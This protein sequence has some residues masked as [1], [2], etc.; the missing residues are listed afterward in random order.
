MKKVDEL[1]LEQLGE[2]EG[3]EDEECVKSAQVDCFSKDQEPKK[4]KRNISLRLDKETASDQELLKK[5]EVCG[6]IS[7]SSSEN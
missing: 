7:E 6:R 2:E 1:Q 4:E 5:G 3:A